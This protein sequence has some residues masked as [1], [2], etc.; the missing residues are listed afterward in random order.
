MSVKV[1]PA[2][3]SDAPNLTEV[4]LS[5]FSDPF[6]RTM[7]PPTPDVHAWVTAHLFGGN[8]AQENEVILKVTLTDLTDEGV[9]VAF[10]KWICPG[11][12]DPDR[13]RQ[14]KESGDSG[15]SRPK[16]PASSNGELCDL[17]FGTM[18]G[19]HHEL[20]GGKPHYCM[21]SSSSSLPLI[22]LGIH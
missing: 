22:P 4:F 10:A 15:D 7:F 18:E 1:S 5:A 19:H 6:N 11:S 9:V 8:G 20:M 13:D 21:D 12:A 14:S 2:T 3:Q 16:W 17:F